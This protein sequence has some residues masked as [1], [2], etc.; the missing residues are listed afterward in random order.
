MA[1]YLIP[2]V[3]V[4]L[5]GVMAPGPITAATLAAGSQRRHAGLWI[6]L[7]HAVIEVPLIL[8]LAAGVAES[9]QT[10]QAAIGT[11]VG[12]VGGLFLVGMGVQGLLDL[13]RG[14]S[15]PDARGQAGQN[16]TVPAGPVARL[17]PAAGHPLALGVVLTVA[18]PYFLIWWATV[19]LAFVTQGVR[20]GPLAVSLFVVCH[21]L[22]DLVWLEVLSMASFQG[23]NVLGGGRA[24]AILALCALV[25]LVFGCKFLYDALVTLVRGG[26]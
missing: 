7:G 2:A 14:G 11:I 17:P 13:R 4:S 16:E 10:R 5:S 20:L 12:L 23:A 3:L 19:G 24:K 22:C 9:L 21:W 25:L 18:N 1:E 8:L 26:A 6:S 15:R